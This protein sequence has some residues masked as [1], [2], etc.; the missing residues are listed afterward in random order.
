M[1]NPVYVIIH[2]LPSLEGDMK[3]CSTQ[4]SNK[5]M[6]PEGEARGRHE[7]NFLGGTNL[8]VSQLTQQ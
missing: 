3:I 1:S 4:K 2:L 5:F 7:F 8:H 6:S